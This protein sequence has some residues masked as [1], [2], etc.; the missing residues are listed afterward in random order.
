MA[1]RYGTNWRLS[2]CLE[3]SSENVVG[4]VCMPAVQNMLFVHVRYLKDRFETRAWDVLVTR[5]L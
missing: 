4:A 2:F 3:R 1:V 5:E